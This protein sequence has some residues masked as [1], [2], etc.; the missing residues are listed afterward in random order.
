VDCLEVSF[1]V[2]LLFFYFFLGL[3]TS[4]SVM[5]SSLRFNR[6]GC[7]VLLPGHGTYLFP[8]VTEMSN[9]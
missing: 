1:F 2:A 4:G 9:G 3:E 6:W 8:A 7:G 5:S